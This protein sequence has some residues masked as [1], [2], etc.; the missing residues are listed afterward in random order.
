MDPSKIMIFVI[1]SFE[2][3]AYIDFIKMR[4]LQFQKY[5]IPHA[6]VYDGPNHELFQDPVT[7]IFYEKPPP[8][9]N[10][11]HPHLNPHMIMKFM[12]A[13]RGVNVSNYT[14]VIRIN[15]STYINIPLLLTYLQGLSVDKTAAA[16]TMKHTLPDCSL[17]FYKTNPIHLLS[18]CAMIFTMDF[19]RF[20][21]AYDLSNRAILHMHCD[22][23][24]LSHLAK[25]YGCNFVHIPMLHWWFDDHVA[26]LQQAILIRCK[27]DHC[28]MVDV[29]KWKYL[30]HVNDSIEYDQ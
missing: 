9:E 10:I 18:G 25:E 2:N 7:D 8:P 23:V 12:K 24:V 6:F 14:F 29:Q 5:N 16:Y 22:D 27:N 28:R 13:V 3:P 20:L 1:A 19:V 15:L 4:K 11:V 30:L 26:E 17:D 21:Q